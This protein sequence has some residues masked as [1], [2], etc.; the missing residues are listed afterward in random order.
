M[1]DTKAEKTGPSK[2]TKPDESRE[3]RL[4]AALRANLKRRKAQ[5]RSRKSDGGADGPNNS[6]ESS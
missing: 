4:S 2:S 6:G 1:D 5:A 3:D